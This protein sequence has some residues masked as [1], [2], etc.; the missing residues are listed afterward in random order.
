MPLGPGLSGGVNAV[1]FS[2]DGRFLAVAGRG[3][4]EGVAGFHQPGRI[5]PTKGG[6]TEDMQLDEG[7]IYLIDSQTREVRGL[8]GHLG[9]VLALA[10]EADSDGTQ[11]L[12][13]AGQRARQDPRG[14]R[15]RPPL[16]CGDS[17][18]SS[19]VST[20]TWRR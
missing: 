1:A 3:V 10:F 18:V 20:S 5:L 9:P 13:S 11:V 2:P 4:V 17:R 7:V 8:P 12:A 14:R 15:R 16:E 6:M 19:E